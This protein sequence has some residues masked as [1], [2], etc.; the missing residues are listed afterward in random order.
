MCVLEALFLTRIRRVVRGRGDS[1]RGEEEEE[2][3]EVVVVVEEEEER[4]FKQS[5]RPMAHHNCHNLARRRT[6]RTG[7]TAG[8]QRRS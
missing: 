5:S 7:S 6:A 4:W 8:C 3:E 1:T 2:E